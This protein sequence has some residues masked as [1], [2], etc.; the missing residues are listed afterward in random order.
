MDLWGRAIGIWALAVAAFVAAVTIAVTPPNHDWDAWYVLL[1]LATA[2]TLFVGGTGLVVMQDRRAKPRLVFGEPF[3]EWRGVVR[4][5]IPHPSS[6]SMSGT[7]PA[8]RSVTATS[9]ADSMN[10]GPGGAATYLEPVTT[11]HYEEGDR[12]AHFAY[13]RVGNRPGRDG[14]DALNVHAR[15]RFYDHPGVLLYDMV[16]RWSEIVQHG[17]P[18]RTL[19]GEEITIPSNGAERL[20]DVA[21][22]YPDDNTC[23][24]FNDENRFAAPHD[25]R[26]RA[27]GNGPIRVEIVIQGSNASTTGT[28]TL[29]HGGRGTALSISRG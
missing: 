2:G 6:D 18:E 15:V 8:A 3:V 17:Y 7:T 11:T 25:L 12:P 1:L 14:R 4:L 29:S 10:T 20:L 19:R 26:Y 23:F 9:Y 21:F 16:G 24:A 13:V 5:P 22:K 28:F 27:L